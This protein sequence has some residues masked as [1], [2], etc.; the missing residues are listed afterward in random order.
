MISM[1]CREKSHAC[2]VSRGIEC[3]CPLS[4]RER[5]RV[6]AGSNR[7]RQSGGWCECG[8][9]LLIGKRVWPWKSFGKSRRSTDP[10]KNDPRNGCALIQLHSTRSP[11]FINEG[12]RGS[13]LTKEELEAKQ[14]H[15]RAERLG[16]EFWTNDGRPEGELPGYV[17]NAESLLRD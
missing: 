5:V 6:R 13:C 10:R 12:G 3:L 8:E 14:L 15:E 17:A 11:P 1:P 2:A 7:T 9:M 4:L 16:Y